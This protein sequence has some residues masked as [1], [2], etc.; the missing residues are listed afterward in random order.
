[1]NFPFRFAD[2]DANDILVI[3]DDEANLVLK[4]LKDSAYTNADKSRFQLLNQR[5]FPGW[6]KQLSVSVDKDAVL[7]FGTYNHADT[8]FIPA[9]PVILLAAGSNE[10]AP[11]FN[12]GFALPLGGALVPA[13][14]VI[15]GTAVD[16]AGHIEIIPNVA[17]KDDAP[18]AAAVINQPGAPQNLIDLLTTL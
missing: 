14:K 13:I 7:E 17:E 6:L 12:T 3:N 4:A 11:D 15:A 18:I 8:Q 16:V 5:I 9:Y 10:H 1:M 2:A